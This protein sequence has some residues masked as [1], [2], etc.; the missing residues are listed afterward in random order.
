MLLF[1]KRKIFK[2]LY[3][4][5]MKEFYAI[6]S[7]RIGY[8]CD[9]YKDVFGIWLGKKFMKYRGFKNSAYGDFKSV[10]SI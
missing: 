10:A 5:E 6:K 8:I 1:F 7:K 4:E 9:I 3:Y 2:V